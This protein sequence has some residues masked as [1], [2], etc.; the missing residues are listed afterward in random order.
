MRAVIVI[1]H[2]AYRSGPDSA[3]ENMLGAVI[4][5]LQAGWSVELDI[6]FGALGFY[7]SHDR[8][9]DGGPAAG[10]FFEAIRKYA[11][12]P[13][14][15]NVKELGYEEALIGFL[16]EHRVL[17]RV[18]LFDMELVEREPGIT[19]RRFRSLDSR[20]RLAARASD[21]AE[22]IDRVLGIPEAEIVWLDEFDRLWIEESHVRILK[23]QSRTVY[24]LSPEI[25]GFS[26]EIMT[27]RWAQF[28]A[29]G[30]DGICTDYP[31]WLD[32]HFSVRRIPSEGCQH[33]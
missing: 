6:R 23:R 26:L 16:C 22:P 18:F 14:A 19:A 30:V 10:P 32:T 15:V 2:R 4:E 7:I 31:K 8:Q 27:Q 12:R 21:R 11:V 28:A 9:Q 13:V 1:A 3:R 33:Q 20:I 5:C 24:A 29:W 25:H 17:D